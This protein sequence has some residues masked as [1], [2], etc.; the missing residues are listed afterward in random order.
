MGQVKL[1]ELEYY[2]FAKRHNES[3]SK[4]VEETSKLVRAGLVTMLMNNSCDPCF[5]PMEQ[6]TGLYDTCIL[7]ATLY[8]V[9]VKHY[10]TRQARQ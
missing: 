2:S 5:L 6:A 4:S 3:V 9:V 1:V 7:S 8:Y 10:I